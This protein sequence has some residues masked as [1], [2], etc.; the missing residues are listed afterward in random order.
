MKKLLLILLA[1]IN[2][3]ATIAQLDDPKFFTRDPDLME[4]LQS[5]VLLIKSS[6]PNRNQAGATTFNPAW[7]NRFQTVLDSVMQANTLN[8]GASVA[9]YTPEE[10]M[11][12]GVSGISHPGVPIT[13]DMRFGIGSNT[14]LF[15]A[16]ALVRLQEQGVLTLDDHLYQW[17]PPIQNVDSTTTIRQLL[18][19]QSGIFDFWNDNPSFLSMIWADTSRFWTPEEVLATIGAPHFAPGNGF[20]YSNT[21]YLLAALVIE[22]ATGESWV[23]MLHDLIFDPLSLDSTFVGA[24]EPGNGTVAAEWDSFTNHLIVNS[25]MTAEY[26]M[27]HAAGGILATA[28]EMVQWYNALFNSS[29]ISS[30]SLQE[31]LTFDPSSLYGLGIMDNESYTHN[32]T[33]SGGMLGYGSLM[34]YDI[35][36]KAII[37]LMFNDRYFWAE[38]ILPLM[39]VFFYEYPKEPNDAGIVSVISP[40]EMYCNP[41]IMPVIE[42]RNFGNMPLTS[43]SINYRVDDG[44]VNV[45]TWAG[46]LDPGDIIQVVLPSVT[47][48]EGQHSFCCY[49]ALPNGEP[50]GY[51]FNDTIRSNFF[52]NNSTP[53]VSWLFEGFEGTG[54]PQ[55]GW[56]M[57]SFSI[58]QW[59]ETTLTSFSG[60]GAG[61]KNNYEWSGVFGEYY[62]ME[63]PRLNISSLS[64]TDFSFDYAYA[65]YPGN[66]EDSLLVS[67]S[68]NCG[69]TWQSLFYKGG[70]SLRTA[71]YH[72]EVFYPEGPDEWNHE[73]FSLSG[74]ESNILIRFRMRYGVS[75]NLYIDNIM[76]GL[77][78]SIAE[79]TGLQFAVRSYPNPFSD[80]TTIEYELEHNATVNLSIYNY[81]GQRVAVLVDGE[82]VAGRQTVQWKAE[83]LPAG[84]YF[85]RLTAS[86]L[87]LPASG[88]R[89]PAS[90]SRPPATGLRQTASGKIVK[91]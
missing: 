62:D 23:Q 11:W 51:G 87:R 13:P 50:E 7:A 31:V 66:W 1:I 61:V 48:A 28:S 44:T 14:K 55:E 12:T 59:G 57:N 30:S 71:P 90:G 78:T 72:T 16:I 68:E 45:F 10:G 8:K 79:V 9:V 89:P 2:C 86:G 34:V 4:K 64:G 85:C 20:R 18:T 56:T 41:L 83:N 36:R 22:A 73:S 6:E 58:L 46:L 69:E 54:F 82:Q 74:F 42:L 3:L 39:N 70:N 17:L 24:Y 76:V 60:N 49:T 81:F 15:V 32:Y 26:S 19:H 33:H 91:Y 84:V 21:N 88:S 37:C 38:K 25:P 29:V 77:P 35:Q 47:S 43:A 53:V 27:V 5:S 75:N 52:I 67:V 65:P 63:L 40:W 80:F